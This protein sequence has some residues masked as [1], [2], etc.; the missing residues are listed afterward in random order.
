MFVVNKFIQKSFKESFWQNQNME[1]AFG[2]AKKT[3]DLTQKLNYYNELNG[4]LQ[5]YINEKQQELLC[6]QTTDKSIT[7]NQQKNIECSNTVT[8]RWRK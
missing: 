8:L 6:N 2:F 1:K 4:L 5:P 7:G 3:L